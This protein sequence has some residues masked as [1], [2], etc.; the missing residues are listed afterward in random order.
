MKFDEAMKL[1]EQGHKVTR[2]PWK[3]SIYFMVEGEDVRS[4]QPKL[5]AYAYNEDIM[6]S[7]GWLVDDKEDEYKFYDIIPLLIQGSKAKLK[8]WKESFIYLEPKDKILVIH[9]MD[10]FPFI[11][12]FSAFVATDW[13]EV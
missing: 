2:L 4:Y 11:P 13:V 9:S 8:D 6:V 10:I 12:D 3:G 5:A 1:L 7:D